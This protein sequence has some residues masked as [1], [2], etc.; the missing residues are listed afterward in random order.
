MIGRLIA[1]VAGHRSW[2]LLLS[3]AAAGAALYAWGAE[4]RA[5]RTRLLAWADSVCA[6]AGAQLQPAKGARGTA[7]A[8]A[9][10][11]LA[12][13]RRETNEQTAKILIEDV[14]QRSVKMAADAQSA[15]RSADAARAA[16][17]AMET[18]NASVGTD[19]RVGSDWLAAFNRVAGLR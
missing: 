12:K 9:V 2:L 14:R 8:G 17:Q 16:E 11:E 10:A 3:V 7:C 5:D 18:A 1:L 4:G 13:F 6:S 19:D 15:R